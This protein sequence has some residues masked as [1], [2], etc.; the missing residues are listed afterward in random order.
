MHHCHAST[1][2]ALAMLCLLTITLLGCKALKQ[3]GSDQGAATSAVAV[4]SAG[5]AL[6][7]AA[8]VVQPVTKNPR[9][10]ELVDAVRL[11]C[12]YSA[13]GLFDRCDGSPLEKGAHVAG[14][15][16]LNDP[17]F[18]E[19]LSVMLVEEKNPRL[20]L[21]AAQL[22]DRSGY[23]VF[24]GLDPA[25]NPQASAFVSTATAQRLLQALRTVPQAG[26]AVEEIVW[27]ATARG[28]TKEV[29]ETLN[30]LPSDA[31]RAR[32]AR[33]SGISSLLELGR[34]PAF[35]QVKALAASGK[36]GDAEAAAR[37]PGRIHKPTAAESAAICPWLKQQLGSKDQNISAA[38][39]GSIMTVCLGDFAALTTDLERRVAAVSA[40][41]STLSPFHVCRRP[42]PQAK[43]PSEDEPKRIVP[44]AEQC[45][46]VFLLVQKIADDPRF[47][48][49]TRV[50]A[51]SLL[52]ERADDETLRVCTTWK[53]K[54]KSDDFRIPEAASDCVKRVNA[55]RAGK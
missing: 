20:V 42:D 30:Q 7:V 39:A 3:R 33:Q 18:V 41:Q 13:Q 16:L 8:A 34:L 6:A 52:S 50:L 27:I 11:Y 43:P 40:T 29:I 1:K 48:K 25:K 37:A 17:T 47:E 22:L 53:A 35:E 15:E 54:N 4:A 44:T 2:Q 10:V 9:V 51:F 21:A 55:A 46:S 5:P 49:N 12:H 24:T 45:L 19:S 14:T 23:H 38:A 36:P 26:F 28:L 32:Q 31:E